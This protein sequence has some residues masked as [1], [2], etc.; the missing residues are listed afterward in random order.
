MFCLSRMG[1]ESRNPRLAIFQVTGLPL[2]DLRSPIPKMLKKVSSHHKHLTMMSI[3]TSVW[4]YSRFNELKR[5]DKDFKRLNKSALGSR[6]TTS[7]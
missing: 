7:H 6:A 2:A 5:Q 1:S 4:E 3:V